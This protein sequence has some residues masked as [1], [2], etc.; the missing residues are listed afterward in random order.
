MN[1]DDLSY[2]ELDHHAM[3]RLVFDEE[4]LSPILKGHIFIEKVLETLISRNLVEPKAFFKGNRS[5]DLKVD[6]ALSMG[7]IDEHY[8]S[9]F[10][11]INK[12]RNNYA[13]KHDYKVSFSDLNAFK[14]DWADIQ[15]QA[16]TVACKQGVGEAARIATIFLCWKAIHLISSPD[17][18]DYENKGA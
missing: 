12:V 4:E 13:H 5:F 11:A 1:F 8:Y 7:L 3:E 18:D 15:N 6:L 17:E 2:R 16:F 14:F 10:K 9:A